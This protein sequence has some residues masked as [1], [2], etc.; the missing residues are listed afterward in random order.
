MRVLDASYSRYTKVGPSR[1]RSIA[2][3]GFLSGRRVPRPSRLKTALF[4]AT[5]N[6][7]NQH[8]DLHSTNPPTN[9][10]FAFVIASW[11]HCCQGDPM[12]EGY[13]LLLIVLGE[14]YVTYT[15]CHT[16][17]VQKVFAQIER[18]NLI[19]LVTHG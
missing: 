15:L 7:V 5:Q 17:A 18:H 6:V 14:I 8:A 19:F 2:A 4:E 12:L 16:V 1:S 11:H 3:D 13:I 10:A 9:V